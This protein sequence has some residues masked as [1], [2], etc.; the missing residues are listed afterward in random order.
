MNN[1][2][3]YGAAVYNI[4]TAEYINCS[5]TNNVAYNSSAGYD[6]NQRI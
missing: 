2:A 5:A 4:G 1:Y 3:K 6:D